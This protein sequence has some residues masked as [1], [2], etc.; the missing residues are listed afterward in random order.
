MGIFFRLDGSSGPMWSQN[1]ENIVVKLLTIR[2]LWLSCNQRFVYHQ[3]QHWQAR[4]QLLG[5]Q[6][7]S[8]SVSTLNGMLCWVVPSPEAFLKEAKLQT[9]Q[10]LCCIT[11]YFIGY[12]VWNLCR[13]IDNM[14]LKP[15]LLYVE[16]AKRLLEFLW[17]NKL[18]LFDTYEFSRSTIYA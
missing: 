6:L 5:R 17:P 2:Q 8:S 1:V 18:L 11:D 13:A 15:R 16:I 7:T 10:L 3:F 9:F 12:S 4:D 14:F